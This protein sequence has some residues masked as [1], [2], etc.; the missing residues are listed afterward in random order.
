MEAKPKSPDDTLNHLRP[1]SMPHVE[2]LAL[3]NLAARAYSWQAIA[4]LLSYLLCLIQC[5]AINVA[6]SGTWS[7]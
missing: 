4:A 3:F 7:V 2:T 6:I 1:V 5:S